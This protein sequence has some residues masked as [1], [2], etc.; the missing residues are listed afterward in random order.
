M[1]RLRKHIHESRLN[2]TVF[3]CN[4]RSAHN[5][6]AITRTAEAIGARTIMLGGYTPGPEDRFGRERKEFTKASLGAE[7]HLHI[8]H[9][10]QPVATLKNFK[11]SGAFLVALEQSPRAIDYKKIVVPAKPVVVIFGNEV[12]G[13]S[14]SVLTLADVVAEIPMRGRKESLNV[15]VAAGI[16]LFHLFNS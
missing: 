13:L 14:K 12:D 6:G 15:S 1:K 9:A 8:S 7:H 4:V 3:L 11:R 2:L 5:A 16:A 10:P